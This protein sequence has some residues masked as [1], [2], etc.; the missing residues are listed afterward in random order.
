MEGRSWSGLTHPDIR[1]TGYA[2][3]ILFIQA[4]GDVLPPFKIGLISDRYNMNTAFRV[5]ALMFFA[6][7][8]RHGRRTVPAGVNR[9]P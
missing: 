9:A 7:R 3:N 2:L 5:V 6:D 4:L 1:A 8:Q